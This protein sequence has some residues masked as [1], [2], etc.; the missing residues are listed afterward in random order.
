MDLVDVFVNPSVVEQS[1]AVVEPDVV[2][3]HADQD[4]A[5]GRGQ[6]GQL[7]EVPLWW[8]RL[9]QTNTQVAGRNT[10]GYLNIRSQVGLPPSLPPSHHLVDDHMSTHLHQLT[11]LQG[12]VLLCL[13]LVPETQGDVT[14]LVFQPLS[15]IYLAR[16]LGWP[17]R[18]M[19]K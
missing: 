4:V 12:N 7:P 9:V 13:Y 8:P 2:A 15:S 17:V 10:Q 16:N 19:N 3:E 14:Q 6:A 1:V 18:S 5:E 11:E